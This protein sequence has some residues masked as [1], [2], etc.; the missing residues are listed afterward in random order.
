[1]LEKKGRTILEYS[2]NNLTEL[3]NDVKQITHAEETDN[4]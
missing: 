1:M 2:Y 4:S 3:P